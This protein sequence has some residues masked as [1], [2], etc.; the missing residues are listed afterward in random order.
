MKV[1]AISILIIIC[2]LGGCRLSQSPISSVE[3]ETT[4]RLVSS[5]HPAAETTVSSNRSEPVTTRQTTTKPTTK[6]TATPKATTGSTGF[7]ALKPEQLYGYKLIQKES[8]KNMV[9]A[10]QRIVVAV[11]NVKEYAD[12]RD[13]SL[14]KD[15]LGRVFYYYYHDYPNHFWRKSEYRYEY[16]DY[17]KETITKVHFYYYFDGDKIKIAAAKN[18]FDSQVNTYLSGINASMNDVEKELIIHD[19]L[20]KSIEYD[21]T[22]KKEH[23]FSSYGAL[24]ENIAVCEGYARAFQYLLNRVGI[25]NVVATGEALDN[26]GRAISHA[27]NVVNLDGQYYHVDVTW[28][29][30]TMKNK[31]NNLVMYYYFNVTDTEIFKNHFIQDTMSDDGDYRYSVPVPPATGTK[32][33]YFSYKGLIL[34]NLSVND[35]ADIII[36]AAK[37]NSQY[38]H[39]KTQYKM[40]DINSFLSKNFYAIQSKVNPSVSSPY[41]MGN[42]AGFFQSDVMNVIVLKYV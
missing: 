8:N 35:L 33:N 6:S 40:N 29:D 23:I 14:N 30:A 24:V 3:T 38:A 42:K 37:G 26:D 21:S 16:V 27:W 19:K 1:K 15:E 28:D 12:I 13:L 4:D 17:G 11:V 34:N 31:D 36:K 32:Y 41:K 39:F 2:L 22:I 7:S 10:Y 5:S 9:K 20:V 25:E 18:K